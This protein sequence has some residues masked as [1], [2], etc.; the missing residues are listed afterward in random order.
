MLQKSKTVFTVE[1]RFE[2]IYAIVDLSGGTSATKYPITYWNKM[3]SSS[4]S[5]EYK[6][7]K[8]VLRR[9]TAGKM[10][11]TDIDITLTKDY[12]VGVF[13]VTQKQWELVMG[14]NPSQYKGNT[15]PVET[16]SYNDIRG[17]NL[18]AKWPASNAVDATS[19]MG[20]L[21]AKTGIDFDLPTEAQWEYACRAGS[22]GDYGF[23]A[24]GI[25]GTLA[26]M[27]WR[28]SYGSP[29]EVGLKTPNMWG[30]YDMHGNIW[31]WCL[32]WRDKSTYVGTDP[33]G[34]LSASNRVLRGGS[35]NTDSIKHFSAYDL[36]ASGSPSNNRDN[37]IDPYGFRL[38]A[39]AGIDIAQTYEVTFNANGGE[40]TMP[41]QTFTHGVEQVLSANA[42]A[43]KG[44]TFAGW[45]TSADGTSGA[46]PQ[47]VGQYEPNAWGLYDMHGNDWEWCLTD[48]SGSSY[49]RL[50]GCI[51]SNQ[52]G[53]SLLSDFYD[54][55]AWSDDSGNHGF[56]I[57]LPIK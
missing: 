39:P 36:S 46:Y 48:I 47:T 54:N 23:I 19:F 13:E 43:R 25:E 20:K 53:C 34:A 41:A 6:T 42:F 38:A 9:I 22:S 2:A 35:F 24:D 30:I 7:T 57:F 52:Q 17:S 12:Y 4:W 27:A 50:G 31:E 40:G 26:K 1:I 15:Q 28:S 10:P 5:N 49:K 21:R 16:V 11:R 3:P 44:Y 45:A 29:T 37:S 56:R 14:S 51:D 33:K 18:G 32:D 8:L 55:M